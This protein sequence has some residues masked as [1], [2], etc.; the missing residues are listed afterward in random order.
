[1]VVGRGFSSPA[2]H[3]LAAV[4]SL[5]VRTDRRMTLVITGDATFM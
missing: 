1:M 3:F 4:L 5:R 2:Y